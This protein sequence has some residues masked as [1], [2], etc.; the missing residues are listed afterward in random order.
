[1]NI[2]DAVRDVTISPDAFTDSL[3]FAADKLCIPNFRE[4]QE[5]AIRKCL[6]G[7]DVFLSLPT[8]Y[9]K[10]KIFQ[11]VPLCQDFL[12]QANPLN[13][14]GRAIA[15]V[16]S[17]IVAI[18][19]Q[20]V[21]ELNAKGVP[22]IHLRVGTNWSIDSK[23]IISG[24]YSILYGSPETFARSATKDLLASSELRSN[25]CGIFVDESHCIERW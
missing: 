9:G 3:K 8:N 17:P 22:A 12:N 1:M 23:A 19:Q 18:I 4:H 13:K 14:R 7:H 2:M 5:N 20:Q 21:A 11:G 24:K 6:N 10:S 15:I 25:I 16:I